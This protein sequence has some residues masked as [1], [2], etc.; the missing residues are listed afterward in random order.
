MKNLIV[1]LAVLFVAGHSMANAGIKNEGE[2][3]PAISPDGKRIAYH[4]NTSD[5][6]FDVI[7][8][9]L[10]TG[11]TQNITQNNGYDTDPS[12]SPN[13]Q[14]LIFS[15][16]QGG[17]WDIYLYDLSSLETKT[18]ISSDSM[19][20]QARWSP[21]GQSIAFLSRREGHSQIYLYELATKAVSRLTHTDQA[22][23]HPSWSQDGKSIVFDQKVGN[24]SMIYQVNISTGKHRKLFEASGSTIAAKLISDKLYVTTKRDSSWDIVLFDLGTKKTSDIA[25]S[26]FDEM[27]ADLHLA[28][29]LIA[30]SVKRADGIFKVILKSIN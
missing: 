16:N 5:H 25:S 27:K 19:D 18:L 30:Y 12:W 20:N 10:S 14:Q 3:S 4:S 8:E 13:G 2:Y 6:F 9:E 26:S 24:K 28:H 23:F 21:D 15:S 17:Q 29:N 11:A 7:V 1:K 22:V